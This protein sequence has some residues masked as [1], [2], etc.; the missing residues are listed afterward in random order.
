MSSGGATDL[1][2]GHLER[3]IDLE[4]L[5]VVRAIVP[6]VGGANAGGAE[7]ERGDPRWVEGRQR[8]GGAPLPAH[9]CGVWVARPPQTPQDPDEHVRRERRPAPDPRRRRDGLHL[10]CS[11]HYYMHVTGVFCRFSRGGSRAGLCIYRTRAGLL[12]A[13]TNQFNAM[14]TGVLAK[15]VSN[16]EYTAQRSRAHIHRYRAREREKREPHV[17]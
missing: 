6:D 8:H 11:R 16:T 13:N 4:I 2:A 1:R 14:C 9:Q 17:T 3:S 12:R 5:V 15:S 10:G 7:E